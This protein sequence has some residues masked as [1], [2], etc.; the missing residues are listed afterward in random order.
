MQHSRLLLAT[1]PQRTIQLWTYAHVSL[2]RDEKSKSPGFPKRSNVL[3]HVR[4]ALDADTCMRVC[5]L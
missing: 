3:K 1:S 4:S 5:W 2:R